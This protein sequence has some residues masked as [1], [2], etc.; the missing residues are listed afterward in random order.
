MNQQQQTWDP[1]IMKYMPSSD[2]LFLSR[3]P[4][5]P[6]SSEEAAYD[7]FLRFDW[8]TGKLVGFECLDFSEHIRDPVWLSALPDIGKFRSSEKDAGEAVVLQQLLL[9]LWEEIRMNPEQE[10]S[11]DAQAHME[12]PLAV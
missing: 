8:D 5:R 6:A 11:I 1:V 4:I 12:F 2:I 10:E 9:R 7:F 3:I